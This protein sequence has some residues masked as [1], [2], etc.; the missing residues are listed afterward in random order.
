MQYNLSEPNQ[1]TAG[2]ISELL[3]Y[4]VKTNVNAPTE[5][6]YIVA[7]SKQNPLSV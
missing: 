1:G 2:N 5:E 4:L 7:V 3:G 6:N